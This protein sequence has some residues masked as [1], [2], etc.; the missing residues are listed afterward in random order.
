MKVE[1]YLAAVSKAIE[2]HEA[3]VSEA[4]EYHANAMQVASI[5]DPTIKDALDALLM[6]KVSTS[7][8]KLMDTMNNL[9]KWPRT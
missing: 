3:S 9:R 6:G 7:Y 4:F 5:E 2:A 1:H 8:L